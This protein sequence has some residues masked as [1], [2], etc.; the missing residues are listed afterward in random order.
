M[1]PSPSIGVF[2]SGIGGLGVFSEIR[3]LLPHSDL[4]Y[5]ADHARAPYGVRSL[6]EI[7]DRSHQVTEWLIGQG[8]ALVTIACNTAST[9]ALAQLRI[10]HP[11]VVFVGM[12]PAIKPAVAVTGR[13]RVG[14]VATA[15]TFQGALFASAVDRFASD[16]DVVT[17]ACPN[18][19]TI[20][21]EGDIE[22]PRAR[23]EVAACL[24]P[25]VEAQVDVVVLACTHFGALAA[26]IRRELGPEVIVI[27]PAPAVAGQT[28]RVAGELGAGG[29]SGLTLLYSTASPRLLE[30][31]AASHGVPGAATLLPL[32]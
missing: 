26:L 29:G 4:V 20:V 22:G 5:L 28:A 18:W 27:D 24:S 15:A 17:A 3:R 31:A 12:E 2:D 32:P 1:S 25:L 13:Q 30:A 23:S 16:V 9:A 19:V 7:E 11:H 14:V 21:E 6:A 8:C 10:S